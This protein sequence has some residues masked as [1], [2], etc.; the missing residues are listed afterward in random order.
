MDHARASREALS[1]GDSGKRC[2]QCHLSVCR[3]LGAGVF[4][5][6]LLEREE[7][8]VEISRVS[9]GCIRL[10]S[11]ESCEGL[12]L[13][14]GMQCSVSPGGILNFNMVEVISFHLKVS[15]FL[16]FIRFPSSITIRKSEYIPYGIG[17]KCW[18]E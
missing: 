7:R 9:I 16:L 8:V 2:W 11:F 5:V 6:F 13:G 1:N 14:R 10:E 12:E 15:R 17:L 4:C 18:K 3:V